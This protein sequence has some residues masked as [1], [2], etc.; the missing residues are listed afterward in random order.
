MK[1]VTK[2]L[3]VVLLVI[4]I[5]GVSAYIFYS[6]FISNLLKE[7][8]WFISTSEDGK[9]TVKVIKTGYTITFGD[10]SL[11]IY[12]DD[13]ELYRTSISNGGMTLNYSN[14]K[15]TWDNDTAILELHGER[16]AE[17]I[18][19]TFENDSATYHTN[20]VIPSTPTKK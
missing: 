2:I 12:A 19:I 16:K 11:V 6:K 3:L 15:I 14:Y 4:I 8:V 20:K 5:L 1:N 9:H 10:N 13:K 18:T 17:T 7:D